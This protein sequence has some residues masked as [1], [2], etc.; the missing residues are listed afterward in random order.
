MVR[1]TRASIW[2]IGRRFRSSSSDGDGP[3]IRRRDRPRRTERARDEPQ[4][5]RE[6][7]PSRR[8]A[9]DAMNMTRAELLAGT[10]RPVVAGIDRRRPSRVSRRSAPCPLCRSST[11]SLAHPELGSIKINSPIRAGGDAGTARS[12]SRAAQQ[13]DGRQSRTSRRS[14]PTPRRAGSEAAG[15]LSPLR[16]ANASF[17]TR[18]V[19]TAG[20][21]SQR[22]LTRGG[23]ALASNSVF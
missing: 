1:L 9:N 8:A 5:R 10:P 18:E 19:P 16:E 14:G 2:T 15:R 7:R 13:L 20:S 17:T 11:T 21:L 3:A 4:I 6:R 23:L 22:W 12:I